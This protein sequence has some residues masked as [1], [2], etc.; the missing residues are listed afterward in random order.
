MSFTDA[1]LLK[2][3]MFVRLEWALFGGDILPLAKKEGKAFDG[4]NA[5]IKIEIIVLDKDGKRDSNFADKKRKLNVPEIPK[6]GDLF[7]LID[8]VRTFAVTSV[9]FE[10]T[11]TQNCGVIVF[12]KPRAARS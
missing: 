10:E 2:I 8:G 9:L 4:A 1:D 12:L 11:P 5:M 7:S 6:K 3:P